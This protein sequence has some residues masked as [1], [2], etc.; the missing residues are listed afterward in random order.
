MRRHRQ[1]NMARAEIIR[2]FKL[3]MKEEAQLVWS[4]HPMVLV[5]RRSSDQNIFSACFDLHKQLTSHPKPQE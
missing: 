2:L 3:M 5:T 1:M 4:F